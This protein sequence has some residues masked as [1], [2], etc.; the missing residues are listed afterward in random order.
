MILIDKMKDMKIYKT[1]TFL[2]THIENKKKKCA[3]LLLT[4]NYE[5]SKK[6][7][8]HPLFVNKLRYQSYWMQRDISYLVS[9]K[10]IIDDEADQEDVEEAYIMEMTAAERNKLPDSAF[11]I[12]SKRKYPLDTEAHVRSAIKFFNYVD[13]EDE[14][15]LAKNIIKAMKKFNITDVKVGDKNRFSKYYKSTNEAAVGSVV[16]IE[17]GSPDI[18]INDDSYTC[19]NC[20]FTWD[21]PIQEDAQVNPYNL[22]CSCGSSD[23][24]LHGNTF[25]CNEC[26]S[27]VSELREDSFAKVNSDFI[28]EGLTV[29]N[30]LMFINEDASNDSQLRRLLYNSRI[31]Q[32]K[33]LLVKFDQVK[34]D[35][36]FIKYTFPEIKKY[37]MRNLYIDLSYYHDIFNQNNVWK[38]FRGLNLYMDFLERLMV[39]SISSIDTYYNKKTIFIPIKDYDT[40]HNASL[41]NFRININPISAIYWFMFRNEPNRLRKIFG[42]NDII[43]IGDS[44]YFKINFSRLED[45]DAKKLSMK[46]KLFITKICKGEEFDVEDI[47]TSAETD[48]SEVIAAKIVDKIEINKGIDLTPKVAAAIQ[49][50]KVPLKIPANKP[51]NAKNITKAVN[52]HDLK[53]KKIEDKI[54]KDTE[55]LEDKTT[56]SK[57]SQNTT[58][59]DPTVDAKIKTD[60]DLE[61]LANSI[62]KAADNTTSEDD[63]LDYM[64]DEE[65][66]NILIDLDNAEQNDEVVISD[67]RRARMSELEKNL[68]NNSVNGKTV[69]DIIEAKPKEIPSIDINVASPNAD[70]WKNLKF[71][72]FDKTYNLEKD[73]INAFNSFKDCI[74]PMVIKEITSEDNSTSEDRVQLYTVNYEDYRGKRF[75]VKLDIPIM[76]DNRFLLRGNPGTIQNQFFN[77][78][79]VKTNEQECQIV[80]NYN[81]IFVQIYGSIVGKSS[82]NVSKFIKA[83]NKYTGRKIKFIKGNNKKISSKYNLPM[84]YI[85]L[86]N[87]YSKIETDEIIIYFNQD[88]IRSTYDI[89]LK[90]GIPV[91]YDKINKEVIYFDMNSTEMFISFLLY[92][93]NDTAFIEAVE[94]NTSLTSCAYS[95]CSLMAAKIPTVVICAYHEGLRRTLDKAKIKYEL[96]DKLTR[97]EKLDFKYDYIKFSDGYIYYELSYES[98]LLLNG[99]KDCPT[100]AFSLSSIDDRKMYLEFLDNFGGRIKADG[101]ENF[102]DLM[103]D[104]IT[105][106][107]LDHYKFPKDYVSILLYANALLSDNRFIKHTDTSSRRIRRYELVAAYTYKVL[108]DAYGAY[109]NELKHRSQ[110]AFKVNQDAVI[111][112]L[113]TDPTFS[114][115]SCIN[116]LREL[117]TT[118]SVTTK[119]LSGMNSDRAYSLDKRTYDDSMLNVLGMSTGFAGNVGVTRQAS[120]NANIDSE[121]G[122]VNSINGDTSKMNDS[123]TLTATELLTPFGSNRDDPMRTAMTYV[124][125][126]KHMVRTLDSDPLLVTNGADEALAYMT[127]DRFAFK[128]KNKG[129][130]SEITDDYIMIDYQDGTSD[131]I[132][133]KQTIEKNSDG[134]YYVP[135]KLDKA[136]EFKVGDKVN[137]N[138]IVAYDKASF[139][140]SVGESD[141]IAYNVGKLAKI[142]I[143]N[144]DEG[145]EDSGIITEKMAKKLATPI[146]YQF[147]TFIDCQ[148]QIYKFAKVGDKVEVNESLMI[149]MPPFDDEAADSLLKN[150]SYDEV[151]ELGKR[152]LTSETTGTI[153]DIKIYR[154]V[155]VEEM[156]E[157][158]QK[159]VNN[160][161]R[162]LKALEKKL[163]AKNIDISQIPAHY[164]LPPVGK[165]K[166]KTKGVLV[167]FYVE[168]LDTVGVGDK[169]VYFS[170]NKATEKNIIPENLEPYTDFRPNE[171]IDAF[172]SETSID[173]RMVTSTLIY[174]SLQ[175]LMIELDRSIKDIMG[176]PYDDS[177]V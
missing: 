161:E 44:R 26:G 28:S 11:G 40:F 14:E 120:V 46:F 74:R 104:P 109:A 63:A 17:C 3:I 16:C 13:K 38:S 101:L 146:N 69:K 97:E 135:L 36:P 147:S 168:Y 139:S 136:K 80:T 116:A 20:K 81:K 71:V 150:L 160:Y 174:G 24:R 113:L 34:S 50:N 55:E 153:T 53:V 15:E 39:K 58:E 121:R 141:N 64:D 45:R 169:V 132:N 23:L 130:I 137:P 31:R 96:K 126:A 83:A 176:I 8:N 76:K 164:K 111:K 165:L 7:M 173:K 145:F 154:T 98:S 41:W 166:G 158:L 42:N 142:A 4:P 100:S 32:R 43:F 77:M 167:E 54:E 133:L 125:T 48:S 12:P 155:E 152:V 123:N 19:N 2:P 27:I 87:I 6:L 33:N 157:S 93:L 103:I 65:I 134:G 61:K 72:N 159:I 143:V 170:A 118:N 144:T 177:T 172:V 95:R 108:A 107:V 56:P 115:D 79:I 67:D 171:S 25:I 88:E 47:D 62:A 119:G 35:C 163:K 114:T 148:S 92:K 86:T 51:V 117:E 138:D 75:T 30:R 175:K 94:S 68:L 78:P 85:D 122:Y 156:S 60:K 129:V 99:L 18:I 140:N 106:E 1:P 57:L 37:Q 128:A 82:P 70:E 49:A 10:G 149:W 9:S 105:K 110:A 73:I 66:R 151:S 127:T 84:D 112:A 29:G 131:Y 89:D 90:L 21:I 124:Q 5:S 162:P 59:K 22:T 102:Y 52:T 91:G